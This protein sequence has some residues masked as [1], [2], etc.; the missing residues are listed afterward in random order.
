[1]DLC[2]E[3]PTMGRLDGELSDDA[4]ER[5]RATGLARAERQ[6]AGSGTVREY[7]LFSLGPSVP[8][9]A[10]TM[11]GRGDETRSDRP[12]RTLNSALDPPHER[13]ARTSR[14][15]ALSDGDRVSDDKSTG[16]QE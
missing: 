1:M 5:A 7:F 4:L 14:A 3:I 10:A 16:P 11:R 6:R 13:R 8:R 15:F 2:S 9:V 12:D